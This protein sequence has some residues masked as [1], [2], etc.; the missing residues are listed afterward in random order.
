MAAK[1]SRKKNRLTAQMLNT[2]GVGRWSQH[3]W[4]VAV[5]I[6]A[7]TVVYCSHKEKSMES[8]LMNI[9]SERKAPPKV[10][11]EDNLPYLDLKNA[12]FDFDKAILR[13]DGKKALA[14]TVEWLKKNDKV[15]LQ[16][17]GYCDERGS[18]AYNLKLGER[19]AIAVKNYI[20]AQG[21]DPE[22]VNAISYGRVEGATNKERA[23]NRRVGLIVIYGNETAKLGKE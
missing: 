2:K 19:R 12:F 14:P 17:E 18:D 13:N 5:F 6:S 1:Q 8:P 7:F 20:L 23:E 4:L 21:I 16:V 10:D 15:R 9:S 22:R 11:L 3:L